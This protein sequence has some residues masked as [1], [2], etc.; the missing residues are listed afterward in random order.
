M[1]IMSSVW[2]IAAVKPFGGS[3][4]NVTGLIKNRLMVLRFSV[5]HVR[6]KLKDRTTQL[7]GCDGYRRLRTFF[8]GSDMV[9]D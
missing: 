1:A 5:Y 9:V 7:K 6:R 2:A 4:I 8:R 3:G